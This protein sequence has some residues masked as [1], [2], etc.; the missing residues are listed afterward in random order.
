[1]IT[2]RSD[3]LGIGS[4]LISNSKIT[5]STYSGPGN[6]PWLARLNTVFDTKAW[7]AAPSDPSP[8][9]Q[10]DLGRVV[11][12]THIAVVGKSGEGMASKFKLSSS[13]DGGFWRIYRTTSG[14]KVTSSA[15]H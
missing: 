8:Y 7:C 11:V 1:M 9:L 10:I 4:G 13:G 6:E 5:S 14:E 12:V 3:P 2:A 15:W